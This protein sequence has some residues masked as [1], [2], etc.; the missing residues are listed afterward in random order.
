MADYSVDSSARDWNLL[1]M[2]YPA[3]LSVMLSVI[4]PE[5]GPEIGP[6]I[7]PRVGPAAAVAVGSGVRSK[8]QQRNG[9]DGMWIAAGMRMA[10]SQRSCRSR[11]GVEEGGTHDAEGC[12]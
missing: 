4:G 10:C 2:M 9:M 8:T 11:W 7:G 6:V 1:I 12:S 5:I 3:M